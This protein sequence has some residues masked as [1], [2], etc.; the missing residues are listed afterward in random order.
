MQTPALLDS[1]NS[2]EESSLSPGADRFLVSV[3]PS[4]IEQ[5][6]D[7]FDSG[8]A[9]L[10]T[11]NAVVIALKEALGSAKT[12]RTV[13]LSRGEWGIS[14]GDQTLPLPHEANQWM[15]LLWDGFLAPPIVFDLKFPRRA[16]RRGARG[17]Y[18]TMAAL[19][20]SSEVA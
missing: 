4:H 15:Q 16:E 7:R 18:R 6:Y 2:L 8:M 17:G 10:S 5:M 20:S 9:D 12:I 13:K 1:R 14:L 11:A 19:G 3:T